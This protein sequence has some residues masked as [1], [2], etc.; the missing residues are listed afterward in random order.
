MHASIYV[1]GYNPCISPTPRCE[2]YCAF[3]MNVCNDEDGEDLR[4]YE[5]LQ[6]CMNTCT[7]GYTNSLPKVEGQ[8]QDKDQ[9]TTACRRYHVYNALLIDKVHCNHAGPGGDG[10]CGPIC[11][12]Y[13]KLVKA[14]CKEGYDAEYRDDQQCRDEC[15]AAY[16]PNVTDA[17]K[18]ADVEYNVGMAQRGDTIQ[19]RLF[20]TSQAF[21]RPT[22]C[23]A[24]LGGGDCSP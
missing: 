1:D 13:C 10:H 23:T 8:T 16:F 18:Q 2:D 24:A 7:K 3:T 9:D 5:S 11:A 15:A 22:E 17:K 14:A 21:S 12:N 4:Q 20:H 19:C 6:E